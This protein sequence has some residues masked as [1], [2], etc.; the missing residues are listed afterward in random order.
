MSAVYTVEQ[1]NF[2]GADLANGLFNPALHQNPTGSGT[3]AGRQV[4]RAALITFFN[5]GTTDAT[6]T[7]SHVNPATG[8]EYAIEADVVVPSGE[9][10]TYGGPFGFML[11]PISA[12][13]GTPWLLKCVSTGADDTCE[14]SVAYDLDTTGTEQPS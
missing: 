13:D 14:F 3:L 6:V 4:W 2:S 7:I 1:T 8:V 10:L 12:D 9:S 11:L 5:G